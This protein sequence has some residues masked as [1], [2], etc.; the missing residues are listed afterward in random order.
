MEYL[1][2]A[3]V[4][5]SKSENVAEGYTYHSKPL[6]FRILV[7][8]ATKKDIMKLF[9]GIKES[10]PKGNEVAFCIS[11]SLTHAK[12]PTRGPESNFFRNQIMYFE[13]LMKEPARRLV[14]TIKNYLPPDR[15]FK[16]LR[17]P[18]HPRKWIIQLLLFNVYN[19]KNKPAF[20][21]D[22]YRMIC[23]CQEDDDILK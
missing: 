20:I 22:P 15:E 19:R 12:D 5:D 21:F 8:D 4:I 2:T 7:F 14:K 10:L 16:L 17:P 13:L 6:R 1:A 18:V 23:K 11:S 3:D 9:E